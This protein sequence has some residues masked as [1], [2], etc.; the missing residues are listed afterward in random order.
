MHPKDNH[1]RRDRVIGKA[2]QVH[3]PDAPLK[4]VRGE[5][6]YLYE[7][8]GRKFLDLQ[9]NVAHVGHC[10][11]H[12]TKCGQE[13]MAELYTNSRY[14]HDEIVHYAERLTAKLPEK[15]SVVFMVCTGTEATD[16]AFRLARTYTKKED[17]LVLDR[18]YHGHSVTVIDLSPYKFALP[19]GD[20][21]KDYIHVTP[22]P[23]TYRGMYTGNPDDAD[24]GKKYAD[25]AKKVI[26]EAHAKGREI[27]M[28]I[29]E[30]LQSC[31]GQVIY[32]P[33]Y[34]KAVYDHV[35][36]A[37][38]VCV[39]D[40][41]Q[42]GFGRS[43]HHGF[44]GFEY[45][46]VVPDI[47]TLGKPMGN[48]HPVSAVVTTQEIADAFAA[49]KVP[50]FNTFGGNPVSC[51]IAN[52]VL[53]VIEDED[54]QQK[55]G[56][57]GDKWLAKLKE[58]APRHRLIG[59]VRGV[60]LFIGIELSKD[61]ESKIPATEEAKLIADKL[62]D[63]GILISRDGPDNNVLKIKPPMVINEEDMEFFNT[64]LEQVMEEVEAHLAQEK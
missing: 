51:A 30:S 15:L 16:L 34:L 9:N 53:D 20:G 32:P 45:H 58:I 19:G 21:Q 54:L 57:L 44:W 64:H 2:T 43:G 52:A 55:A 56:D 41:V 42:V 35:H 33:G 22:C 48:G 14:L 29:A 46:D 27:G 63:H 26:D 61:K 28:F 31:G 18:A 10:H 40:E 25:E 37:G 4:I 17:A 59:D 60:G 50:Y 24:L 13:Q 12:V 38:G 36:A 5:G 11:P 62:K 1:R 8:D 47:V 6:Q 7:E 39:A 3:Y 49:T 23:D